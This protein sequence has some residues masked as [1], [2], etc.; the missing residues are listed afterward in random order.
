RHLSFC[1]LLRQGRRPRLFSPQCPWYLHPV[2]IRLLHP[3]WCPRHLLRQPSCS[4]LL[5]KLG[6]LPPVHRVRPCSH[7]HTTLCTLATPTTSYSQLGQ[8]TLECSQGTACIHS[9]P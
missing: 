8:I 1:P 3:P 2:P 9:D 5:P 6:N 4:S 7:Y